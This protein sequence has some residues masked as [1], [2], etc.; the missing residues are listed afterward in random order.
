MIPSLGVSTFTFDESTMMTTLILCALPS[1]PLLHLHGP[2]QLC[3]RGEFVDPANLPSLPVPAIEVLLKACH[4]LLSGRLASLGWDPT[5][6]GAQTH[7]A[8]WDPTKWGAYIWGVP[9]NPGT[10][11]AFSCQ[12]SR[13]HP[14]QAPWTHSSPPTNEDPFESS[15]LCLSCALLVAMGSSHGSPNTFLVCLS[16]SVQCC[17][18]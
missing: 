3:T 16:S 5:K 7:F 9:S 12:A 10:W 8:H 6:W 11:S 4:P 2:L 15:S 1:R 17:S 14:S 18:Y 13:T